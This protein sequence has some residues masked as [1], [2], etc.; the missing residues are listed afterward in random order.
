MLPEK[1]FSSASPNDPS[2][3]PEPLAQD[4]I[5]DQVKIGISADNVLRP[6]KL[7]RNVTRVESADITPHAYPAHVETAEG[8]S[9]NFTDIREALDPSLHQSE[10]SAESSGSRH[11][12]YLKTSTYEELLQRSDSVDKSDLGAFVNDVVKLT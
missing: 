5:L 6:K 7:Q 4:L 3:L 10:Y 9:L 12:Y 1:I 2:P 11:N 8:D